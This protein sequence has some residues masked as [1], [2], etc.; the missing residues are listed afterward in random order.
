MLQEVELPRGVAQLGAGLADVEME[1]LAAHLDREVRTMTTTSCEGGAPK[2][3]GRSVE[4]Y[5]NAHRLRNR[6]V[7]SKLVGL[8]NGR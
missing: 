6:T 3:Q 1:D 7:Y 8:L 2:R 4:V 5:N